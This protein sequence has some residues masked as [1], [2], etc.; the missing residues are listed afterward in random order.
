MSYEPQPPQSPAQYPQQQYPAQPNPLPP[1]PPA[2]QPLAPLPFPGGSPLPPDLR[3]LGPKPTYANEF[4]NAEENL[5]RAADEK[6]DDIVHFL[7]YRSLKYI[8]RI[9]LCWYSLSSPSCTRKHGQR[10]Y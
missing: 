4:I 7:R 1:Y 5:D 10:P 9:G 3:G 8:V 2:P 6:V